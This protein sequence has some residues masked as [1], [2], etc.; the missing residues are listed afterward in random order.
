MYK[1]VTAVA[2]LMVLSGAAQA[3]TVKQIW[4]QEISE[5]NPGRVVSASECTLDESS[6]FGCWNVH[7]EFDAP[8]SL[9]PVDEPDEELPPTNQNPT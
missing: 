7:D 9:E 1:V 5:D 4:N 6:A 3:D 8:E 2:A